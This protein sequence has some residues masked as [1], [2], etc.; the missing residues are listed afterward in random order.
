METTALLCFV[1]PSQIVLS[2]RLCAK[3][4]VNILLFDFY[5][6]SETEALFS[7]FYGREKW[8]SVSFVTASK[9][10]TNSA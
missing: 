5:N 7:P 2:I 6:I 10:P 1:N 8:G 4:F 9:F 3:G